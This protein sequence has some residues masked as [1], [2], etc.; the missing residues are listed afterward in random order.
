MTVKIGVQLYTLRDLTDKDFIG[1]LREVSKLGYQGVEF[2]GYG[3]LEASALKAVLDELGLQAVGSHIGMDRLLKALPEEIAYN[4]VLGNRNL[5][6]PWYEDNKLKDPE[7]RAQFVTNLA[8]IGQRCLEAGMQLL[9]HNHEFELLIEVDGEPV[10]DALYSS[11]DE[12]ILQLE[13]DSCWVHYAGFNAAEY[14]RKYEGRLPL[15][16][17]KDMRRDAEGNVTTVEL[18]QGEVNLRKIADA[19]VSSNVEWLVVEQDE[20]PNPPLESIATSMEW[21]RQYGYMK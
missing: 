9:Y 12:K 4:K 8:E 21:L 1:T 19:A 15:L 6:I 5:I 11:I 14:I 17:L 18:G 3:G 10:L 7:Q 2:A 13:L 20:C 16:H